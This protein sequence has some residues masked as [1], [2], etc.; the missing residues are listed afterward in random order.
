MYMYVLRSQY[1][2]KQYTCSCYKFV[3]VRSHFYGQSV[4][5]CCGVHIIGY[6]GHICSSGHVWVSRHIE[7]SY[8]GLAQRRE[9]FNTPKQ[10]NTTL[11]AGCVC[12]YSE[13]SLRHKCTYTYYSWSQFVQSILYTTYSK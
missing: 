5:A 2:S 12:V 3:H 7:L 11:S 1:V 4:Q 9:G 6:I 13:A 10:A 8:L